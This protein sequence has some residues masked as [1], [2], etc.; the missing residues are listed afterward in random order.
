MFAETSQ[1]DSAATTTSSTSAA[2]AAFYT[3]DEGSVVSLMDHMEAT[4]LLEP[5][6]ELQNKFA[7]DDGYVGMGGGTSASR[8]WSTVPSS[9]LRSAT[10]A[11]LSLVN[12]A[13]YEREVL[14]ENGRVMLGICAENTEE[15]LQTLK[16][17]VTGLRL[18]RGLLHGGDVDGVPIEIQ[19]AVYI[20][21]STGGAMTFADMR[22]SGRGFDCLWRPGDA[23]LETYDGDFR[24]VYFNAEL[25]DGVFRQYGVLPLNLFENPFPKN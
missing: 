9:E 25:D 20:K 21:Y 18:P 14:G 13:A 10:I 5:H 22:A 7:V 3:T 15:A 17:W 2:A 12:R 8:Y 1:N 6:T 11:I 23:L 4:A 16:H 24:G 19:G